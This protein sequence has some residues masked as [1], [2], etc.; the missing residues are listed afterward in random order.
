MFSPSTNP[1]Q[2]VQQAAHGSIPATYATRETAE[3]ANHG[4]VGCCA[5]AASGDPDNVFFSAIPLPRKA[6]LNELLPSELTARS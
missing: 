3:E 6:L 5:C 2:I 1:F 4:I